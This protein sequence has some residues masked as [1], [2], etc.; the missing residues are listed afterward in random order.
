MIV[1]Y[2]F[3]FLILLLNVWLFILA[4][5]VAFFAFLVYFRKNPIFITID[6]KGFKI[7]YIFNNSTKYKWNS[8]VSIRHK[9]KHFHHP[10]FLTI[11]YDDGSIQ[12][13]CFGYYNLNAIENAHNIYNRYKIENLD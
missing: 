10:L 6:E 4:Y 9:K 8:I 3:A 2:N 13:N 7:K 1:F 11:K 5:V 12:K